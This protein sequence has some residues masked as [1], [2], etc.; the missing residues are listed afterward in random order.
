MKWLLN[1]LDPFAAAKGPPPQQLWPFFRWC[2][3]GTTHWILIAGFLSS[4]VGVI[5]VY[6]AIILGSVIDGALDSGVDS[7]WTENTVLFMGALAFFLLLRPITFGLSS[8]V[9]SIL[10]VTNLNPLGFGAEH[11]VF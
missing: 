11:W 4:L 10:V 9:T 2:I 3:S 5:E 8:A 7:L 1:Q 6:T